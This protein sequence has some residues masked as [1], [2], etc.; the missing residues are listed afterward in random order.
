MLV[1]LR[2]SPDMK[3]LKEM[4][5]KAIDY[6]AS[7]ATVLEA[8][9]SQAVAAAGGT[10]AIDEFINAWRQIE[11]NLTGEDIAIGALLNPRP[12]FTLSVHAAHMH[13]NNNLSPLQTGVAR[14]CA[15]ACSE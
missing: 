2:P 6:A 12:C 5:A 14:A 3:R 7:A 4:S 1:P 8:N 9:I 10:D 13:P 15:T 11:Y